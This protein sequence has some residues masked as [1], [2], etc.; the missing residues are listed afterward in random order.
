VTPCTVL[1]SPSTRGVKEGRGRLTVNLTIDEPLY[2]DAAAVVVG[3][4]L[5]ARIRACRVIG[6]KKWC[7]PVMK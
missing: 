5:K 6:A 4:K 3:V 2:H 1:V 7:R